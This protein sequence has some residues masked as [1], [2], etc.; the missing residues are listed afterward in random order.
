MLLRTPD[1][2]TLTPPLVIE[3]VDRRY[4]QTARF[5]Y[6]GG[7]IHEYADI[8]LKI[9]RRIDLIRACF[10]RFGQEY[11]GGTT[12]Q[13]GVKVRMLKAEVI[14][15]LLLILYGC[16][17]WTLRAEPFAKLRTA[18]HQ[19]LLPVIG[20]QRRLRTEHA[21]PSYAKALNMARCE[22]I[23]TTIRKRQLFFAGGRGTAKQAAIT[24][25][26]D[27]RDDG[28]WGELETWRTVT[29]RLGIAA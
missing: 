23:E 20:F 7:I 26:G 16:T 2:A 19:V 10:K 6:L 11:F 13:L 14:E 3:A 8:S 17:T 5:L 25:L 24:Q 21:T 22:S 9:D 4:K 27:V 28:P 18:R 12:V 29:V 1:Q 15:I